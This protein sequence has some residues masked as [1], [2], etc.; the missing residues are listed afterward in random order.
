QFDQPHR[1]MG[2]YH[3]SVNN[4]RMSPTVVSD[5]GDLL[6]VFRDADAD[7][8]LVAL[9]GA[10]LNRH[11]EKYEDLDD[12]D[13]ELLLPG[14]WGDAYAELFAFWRGVRL[15]MSRLASRVANCQQCAVGWVPRPCTLPGALPTP[16]LSWLHTPGVRVEFAGLGPDNALALA[17]IALG[18]RRPK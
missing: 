7:A 13:F 17:Q 10:T 15:S 16:P 4:L 12:S 5:R 8:D 9:R 1:R 14:V 11:C 3:S 6:I 2:G 18:P